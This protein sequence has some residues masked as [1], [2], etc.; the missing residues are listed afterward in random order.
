VGRLNL[1]ERRLERF[2]REPVS[3]R[4]AAGVIVIWAGRR[5]LDTVL[6]CALALLA[7]YLLWPRDDEAEAPV[8][9]PT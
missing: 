8:P 6:G 3:V 4:N 1:I 9:V 7:T 2:A 5:L